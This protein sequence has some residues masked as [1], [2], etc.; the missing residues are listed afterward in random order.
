MAYGM[1]IYNASG[2]QYD[3]SSQG[4]VLVSVILMPPNSTDEYVLPTYTQGM[5]ITLVPIQAGFHTY[6]KVTGSTINGIGFTKI[7]WEPKYGDNNSY[8]PQAV[9]SEINVTTVL[10]VL[11]K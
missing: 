1:Q 4:G 8:G 2:L 10:L 6:K 9:P 5:E 11:A 3:S 7:Q